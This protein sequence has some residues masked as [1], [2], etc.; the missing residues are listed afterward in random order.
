MNET[1]LAL[2]KK[3]VIGLAMWLS[4]MCATNQ[5]LKDTFADL[6]KVGVVLDQKIDIP[7]DER[8]SLM[9]LFAPS[10]KYD[11]ANPPRSFFSHFCTY[12]REQREA[13]SGFCPYC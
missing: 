5:A 2:C 7:M 11:P 9:L 10:E 8:Y 4:S 6:T 3:P 13:W 1:T 12:S